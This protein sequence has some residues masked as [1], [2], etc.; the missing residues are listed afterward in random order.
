MKKDYIHTTA[1]GNP[2][3][4]FLKLTRDQAAALAEVTVADFVDGR[5]EDARAVNRVKFKLRDKRAAA[6]RN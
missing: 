5:S 3:L 6:E 1:D 4:D 2:Y